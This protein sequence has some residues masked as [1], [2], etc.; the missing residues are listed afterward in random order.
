M[1][2]RLPNYRDGNHTLTGAM[3]DQRVAKGNYK[4]ACRAVAILECHVCHELFEAQTNAADVC[5]SS[6]EK[7]QERRTKRWATR[8]R[9]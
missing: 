6:C 4:R 5:G 8:E 1:S 7:K 2:A 3:I 9:R